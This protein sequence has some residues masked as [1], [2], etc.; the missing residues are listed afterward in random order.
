M[1]GRCGRPGTLVHPRWIGAGLG[2]IAV[3]D[4]QDAVAD[5]EALQTQKRQRARAVVADGLVMGGFATDH[6]AKRHVTVEIREPLGDGDGAGKFQ[7]TGHLDKIV[8]GAGGLDLGTGAGDQLVGDV[9][10]EGRDHDQQFHG[11]VE[12][13]ARQGVIGIGHETSILR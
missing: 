1:Q 6:A 11:F 5:A 12:C 8:A 7:R 9:A 4:G 13:G 3:L 10:I 2:L